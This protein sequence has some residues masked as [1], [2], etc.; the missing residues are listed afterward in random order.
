MTV[1]SSAHGQVDTQFLAYFNSILLMLILF[2]L[3]AQYANGAPY[4]WAAKAFVSTHKIQVDWAVD[5]GSTKHVVNDSSTLSDFEPLDAS[6]V[7]GDGKALAVTGRGTLRFQAYDTAKKMHTITLKHVWYCPE[8]EV[9]LFSMRCWRKLG[10][11]GAVFGD[12]DNRDCLRQGKTQF[13]IANRGDEYV[14]KI[15]VQIPDDAL[16]SARVAIAERPPAAVAS[17]KLKPAA[18]STWHKRLGHMASTAI[19]HTAQHECVHGLVLLDDSDIDS[20]LGTLWPLCRSRF[21]DESTQGY[22]GF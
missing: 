5:S 1:N 9:P 14:W 7:I 17:N 22:Q 20:T 3:Y 19:L 18:H 2:F 16:A 13:P 11:T 4:R 10:D 21:K 8:L 12:P 15:V 6:L